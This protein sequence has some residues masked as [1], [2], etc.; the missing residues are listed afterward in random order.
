MVL[1]CLFFALILRFYGI[2][3]PILRVSGGLI[4]AVSGWKLLNE[5][6][7][8]KES[9]AHDMSSA[10][11][12]HSYAF[13]P[14]TL[15]LTTGPGTIAVTISI[16]LSSATFTSPAGEFVFIIA[17]LAAIT[18][19]AISIWFCFANAD[20]ISITGFFTPIRFAN[21]FTRVFQYSPASETCL[22]FKV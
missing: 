16:G 10:E 20:R 12:L 6:S 5:G 19:I 1:V 13:Y 8:K 3:I 15:P 2:S 11:H 9:S 4:V 7:T 18:L 22:F 14:L 17:S 21:S